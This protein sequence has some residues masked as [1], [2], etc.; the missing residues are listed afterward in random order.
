M[1]MIN[2]T[3]TAELKIASVHLHQGKLFCF[4]NGQNKIK[5]MSFSLEELYEFEHENLHSFWRINEDVIATIRPRQQITFFNTG[6][7]DKIKSIETVGFTPFQTM[8]GLIWG[9]LK[10]GSSERLISSVSIDRGLERHCT[11]FGVLPVWCYDNY[12]FCYPFEHERLIVV[13]SGLCDEVLNE[14]LP[15]YQRN[16]QVIGG[17]IAINRNNIIG[18][19]EYVV[20]HY[21]G[22]SKR[23]V[24]IVNLK[25]LTVHY[26][27]FRGHILQKNGILYSIDTEYNNKLVVYTLE[28]HEYTENPIN[29]EFPKSPQTRIFEQHTQVK[30][31]FLIFIAQVFGSSKKD[32]EVI[33]YNTQ[34]NSI[35]ER[36]FLPKVT[37]KGTSLYVQQTLL[38]EDNLY[39]V[40]QLGIVIHIKLEF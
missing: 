8:N 6:T 14:L 30:D 26:A 31:H 27:S 20:F 12:F 16:D 4:I 39:I 23:N 17:Q 37:P 1:R 22:T 15:D 10:Q 32:F 7:G 21:P 11:V 33:I 35:H 38:V 25:T 28:K 5:V 3:A 40:T 19:N 29:I 36:K 9:F 24:C 34:T 18:H 13:E 2:T